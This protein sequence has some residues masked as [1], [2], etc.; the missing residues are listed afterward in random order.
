MLYNQN[1][2]LNLNIKNEYKKLN[3]NTISNFEKLLHFRG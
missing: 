2:L 1:K 3:I